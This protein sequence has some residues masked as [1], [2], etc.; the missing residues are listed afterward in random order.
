VNHKTFVPH[1]LKLDEAGSIELAFA[2]MNVVDSDGDVTLPGAFPAKDV[3]M[4]AYG[5]TSW[6]GA[7][8]IGKGSISEQGDWAVFKGAFF[9][10][11]TAGR[12]TYAAIKDSGRSPSI[13]TA[14]CRPSTHTAS[15]TA[16]A[17]ASSSTSTCSR[18][19]PS[20]RV[21]ASA[22]TPS[23]SRAARRKPDAPYA[24]HAKWV[25]EAVKAFMDRTEERAEW[26]A[27]EGR[28]LSAAN[29]TALAT[30]LESLR[31][32]GGTAEELA[33]FLDA[34]DPQKAALTV[35]RSVAES[36]ARAVGVPI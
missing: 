24:E 36:R 13:P 7:L 5:H 33:A 22:P 4:S 8:P 11:T 25:H 26:R 12:D 16:R 29:R 3:P 6:D 30:I 21:P 32:L 17:S 27:K 31:S 14:T 2:Q 1:E 23:R 19:L 18:C 20:S 28:T 34:T 10:D 35:L 9:M 15:R